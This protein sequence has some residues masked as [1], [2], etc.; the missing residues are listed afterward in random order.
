MHAAHRAKSVIALAPTT[1]SRFANVAAVAVTGSFSGMSITVVMPPA[2][3]A[4]PAWVK[5][6][7]SLRF[8]SQKWT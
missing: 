6:S 4:R 2:T 1:S 5:S 8:S 7:Q 3:A